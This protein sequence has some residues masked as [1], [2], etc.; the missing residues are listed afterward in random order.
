MAALSQ[1]S[2]R[3]DSRGV[4]SSALH[5]LNSHVLFFPKYH[6]IYSFGNLWQ[7]GQRPESSPP[8]LAASGTTAFRKPAASSRI[9]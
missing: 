8:A 6:S 9:Y 4:L 1:L 3:A 5:A 7:A 2:P